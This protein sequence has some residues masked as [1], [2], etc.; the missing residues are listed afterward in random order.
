MERLR[1][2]GDW[3][4]KSVGAKAFFVADRE[5]ELLI[6]EVHSLKLLQVAR[7]LA[8]ASWAAS[9]QAGGEPAMGSLH[10][11]LGAGSILEVLPVDTQYGALILGL[12]VPGLLPTGTVQVV[13]SSLQKAVN[14]PIQRA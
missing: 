9:R 8:Q 12:V 3:L 10:V 14:S 5:G 6:D 1:S 13:A 7:T 4:H 2:Y 11:K